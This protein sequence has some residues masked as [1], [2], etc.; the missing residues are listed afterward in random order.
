M[1]LN[2]SSLASVFEN[3]DTA[4]AEQQAQ[5]DD[6][7]VRMSK[8]ETLRDLVDGLDSRVLK[9]ESRMKKLLVETDDPISSCWGWVVKLLG[10]QEDARPGGT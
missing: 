1:K 7:K 3:Y 2:L 5:L 4:S 6:L 9:L 10:L 8:V